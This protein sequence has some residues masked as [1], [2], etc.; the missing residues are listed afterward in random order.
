MIKETQVARYS[1]KTN[2]L[3]QNS[4]RYAVDESSAPNLFRDIY[5]YSEVPKITFDYFTVPIS[6]PENIYITDTTFRD[7]QQAVEPYTEEQV[8]DI[9][10]ML[11]RLSGEN[12]IIRQTEFFVYGK[13][14]V[15]AL[16]ACRDLG[17][18]FPEITTWIRANKAD[19]KKVKA[20]GIK[21]TGIL[22]SVSDYF[23]YL[24][25]FFRVTFS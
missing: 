20:L 18:K 21:E 11:S 16:E 19:L 5:T 6:M 4:H 10:T 15:S 17:L 22:T 8:K 7:G 14:D 1:P 25:N 2:L 23:Y 13:K 24:F 3:E 12:G 9:F